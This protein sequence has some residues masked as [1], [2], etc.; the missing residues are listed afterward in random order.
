[1]LKKRI[2]PCLDIKDGRTVKG[3]NFVDIRDAGDPV[4][5][6]KRYVEQ[7][8]DELVFLDITATIEKR[9][10]FASLVGRIA[11]EINL[12]FT[13]GGGIN[14]LEDVA[15]LIKAG[16]DKV[17][18]NSSAFRTPELIKKIAGEF[19]SQC[20]VVAI[21]TRYDGSDWMVYLDGGRTPTGAKASGW[22]REAERLGAGE[23]L[24]TSMNADGT[25]SGFSLDITGEISL[26]V[27]IPVIAS[28]GAGTMK[29]F[30]EVF[31]ETSCSAA[32]AASIF[33]YGEIPIPDLKK[34]L[35]DNNISVR[36]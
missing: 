26:S 4:E 14:T 7:R 15:L 30:L 25:K 12:P 5:L 35:R 1:V 20:V 29:H 19:G 24:L 23:I 9:K 6:A 3:I 27:N 36:I 13:V 21:D 2:I 17:S 34:Y 22:A 28:G 10:T 31:T 18:I 32:L 11:D 8:A 33:H 16:A